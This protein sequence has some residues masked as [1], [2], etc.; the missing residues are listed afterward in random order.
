MSDKK[1]HFWRCGTINVR[2]L[3]ENA[4]PLE[5]KHTIDNIRQ[6]RL[7]ICALQETRLLGKDC[8]DFKDYQMHWSGFVRKREQGVALVFKKHSSI[9]IKSIEGIS[10]RLM[11]ADLSVWGLFIRVIAAYGPTEKSNDSMKDEFWNGLKKLS[12]IE[13]KRHLIILGDF[14]ATTTL[15]RH[16]A[17]Y[18]HGQLIED[19]QHND[20]GNRLV[21]FC[22]EL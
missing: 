5:I 2:S 16:K 21:R 20:N 19:A 9:V 14:N 22:A 3:Q 18:F 4:N 12:K 1:H 11:Y 8:L 13:H 17:T 10:S 15:I 6:S 7:D